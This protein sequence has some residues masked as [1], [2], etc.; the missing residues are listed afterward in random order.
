MAWNQKSSASLKLPLLPPIEDAK[1][2]VP[3]QQ[4]GILRVYVRGVPSPVE[5]WDTDV[6]TVKELQESCSKLKTVDTKPVVF[7]IV[8]D[9]LLAFR[10]MVRT[11]RKRPITSYSRPMRTPWLPVEHGIGQRVDVKLDSQ[12]VRS[13]FSLFFFILS[14]LG[15]SPSYP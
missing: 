3:K 9:E 4:D 6:F 2:T 1:D 12:T 7:F 11:W 15:G 13:S 14:V 8:A 5:E 10:R